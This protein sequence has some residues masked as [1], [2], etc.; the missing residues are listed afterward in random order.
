MRRRDFQPAAFVLHLDVLDDVEAQY[1]PVERQGLVLI[2]DVDDGGR[3]VRDH[4]GTLDRGERA[5]FVRTC[6]ASSAVSV[7]GRPCVGH[8]GVEDVLD[9]RAVGPCQFFA[10]RGGDGVE[11]HQMSGDHQPHHRHLDPCDELI[12]GVLGEF[13]EPD[14]GEFLND[15]G[16]HGPERGGETGVG[17]ERLDR[18]LPHGAVPQ[19]QQ[20]SYERDADRVGGDGEDRFEV[21]PG[22]DGEVCGMDEQVFLAVEVVVQ[23]CRID[24]GPPRDPAQ[25]ARIAVALFLSGRLSGASASV[26]SSTLQEN[27]YS[28]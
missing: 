12:T 24:A 22:V 5:R 16:H 27:A 18:D 25:G 17:G 1:V 8:A 2:A 10:G 19:H 26:L 3:Y 23:Q 9:D 15:L 11:F 20:S 14:G 28:R 21:L 4:V 7:R 13:G 6:W